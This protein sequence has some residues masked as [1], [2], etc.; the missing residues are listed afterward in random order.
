VPRFFTSY[1]RAMSVARLRS[2]CYPQGIG[3][4]WGNGTVTFQGK[5]YQLK[6]N[7]YPFFTLAPATTRDVLQLWQEVVGSLKKP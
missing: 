7:V 1:E 2:I 5:K 3:Y 4:P 6:V